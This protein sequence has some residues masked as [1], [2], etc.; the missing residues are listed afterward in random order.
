[1]LVYRIEELEFPWEDNTIGE[2]GVAIA[3]LHILEPLEV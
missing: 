1:M 2:L 3:V